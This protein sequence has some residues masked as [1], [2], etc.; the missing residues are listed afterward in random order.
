MSAVTAPGLS[1]GAKPGERNT[2]GE[3]NAPSVKKKMHPLRLTFFF[4][5]AESKLGNHPW[6][7]RGV[8]SDDHIFFLASGKTCDAPNASHHDL[9]FSTDS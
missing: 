5:A 4:F 6:V 9:D 1:P 8:D 3:K 7:W 2:A